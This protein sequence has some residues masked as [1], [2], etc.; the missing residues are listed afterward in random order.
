MMQRHLL[1][2]IPLL[3]HL[4]C[5]RS[6]PSQGVDMAGPA[7]LA[8]PSADAAASA[9][10]PPIGTASE[11]EQWLMAGTYKSW[12]CEKDR[13]PPRAGSAHA[14]N[15]ICSNDLLSGSAS[16]EFPVG[17]ASVKE[18]YD[19]AGNLTGFAVGVRTTTGAVDG[20]WFWYERVGTTTYGNGSGVPLCA[21]CHRGAPRDYVFTQ[22]TR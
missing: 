13:H 1:L 21:G 20:A 19:G 18:L 4:A 15:R 6:Q 3:I 10:L 14:A 16:G 2:G 9:Q 11:L 7:D 22:V 5:G 8:R 12:A 17:A